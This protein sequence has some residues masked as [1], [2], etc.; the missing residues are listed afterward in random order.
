MCYIYWI[1]KQN[2]WY[3]LIE[4][5]SFMDC[6]FV[7][8]KI[9]CITFSLYH[10][11]FISTLLIIYIRRGHLLLIGRPILSLSHVYILTLVVPYLF[12]S[13]FHLYN[14]L[15]IASGDLVR[16]QEAGQ[17]ILS[18][19]VASPCKIHSLRKTCWEKYN[20]FSWQTSG[21]WETHETT[22]AYF[23]KWGSKGAVAS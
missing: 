22:E 10:H 4:I 6:N 12:F 13:F 11:H 3:D 2:S 23:C 8:K 7:K 16:K 20:S 17:G 18:Q 14:S 21:L 1:E 9:R 5:V 19:T 15:I